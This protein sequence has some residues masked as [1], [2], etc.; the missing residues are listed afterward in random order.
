MIGN[1]IHIHGRMISDDSPTYFIA[2]IAS[3]HDGSLERAKEL[4]WIAK[5]AGAD[6]AKFQHFVASKIVS[7]EGFQNLKV[8]HQGNWKKSVFEVYKQYELN[9]DWTE[10]LVQTAS[11][12]GIDF[13]TTP[14][15]IEAIQLLK[16][17]VPAFTIGSG[18]VT[19]TSFIEEIAKCGKPVLLATGASELGD[20]DRAVNAIL[21]HNNQLV[22]MQCNTNYTASIENLKYVNL[23]VL[24]TYANRYPNIVLGL[25]DHT[26]GHSTVLGAIALGARVIEKHLTDDNNRV[27]PDHLFSMNPDTWKEMVER[28]RELEAALGNGIKRIEDNEKE[29]SVIQRR[30]LTVARNMCSG[31]V[32]GASDLEVLRPA[33]VDSIP[34][35]RFNEI[36]GKKLTT[37]KKQG[38]ALLGTDVVEEC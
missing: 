38:E 17:H 31:E 23:R 6:A 9:R 32:I 15:D 25:S 3:N 10:Q 1:F 2:D 29:T 5:E 12:A 26:P 13:M 16:E 34:P 18:D 20:V 22:L 36:V 33:P 11:E 28:S 24:Q 30:A 37:D 14:Y 27:G 8:G 35:H 19:W 7:N 4:I 21:A